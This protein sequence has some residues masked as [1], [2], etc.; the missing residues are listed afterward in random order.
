VN[1]PT[2]IIGGVAIFYGLLTIVLRAK[3]PSAFRKLNRMKEL[4]G[5]QA[6]TLLHIFSYS[7][8]PIILGIVL[9]VTG[10]QGKSIF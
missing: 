3:R 8:L 4:Y 5:E 9:L 2:V 10:F 1:T 7:V 6:G